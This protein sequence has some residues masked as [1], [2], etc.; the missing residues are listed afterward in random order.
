VLLNSSGKVGQ[1]AFV[2]PALVTVLLGGL[3]GAALLAFMLVSKYIDH[4][5][6]CYLAFFT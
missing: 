4:L 6:E 5:R 3:P 1:D 2:A